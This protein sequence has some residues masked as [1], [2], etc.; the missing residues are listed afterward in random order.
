MIVIAV[1]I[2]LL[3][4]FC[5]YFTANAAMSTQIERNA[6]MIGS[7]QRQLEKIDRSLERMDGKLDKIL[8]NGSK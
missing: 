2:P 5:F 8:M 7:Q 3:T 6:T 1:V 4:G